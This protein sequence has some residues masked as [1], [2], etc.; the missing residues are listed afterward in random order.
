M[1]S[2]NHK[3]Q[4]DIANYSN[5]ESMQINIEGKFM[6]R[7]LEYFKELESIDQ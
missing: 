5:H 4:N 3:F 1:K 6:E 7:T 2:L